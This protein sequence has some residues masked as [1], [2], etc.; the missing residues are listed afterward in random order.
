MYTKIVL[1]TRESKHGIDKEVL[2]Q[3]A[4]RVF[5]SI[6][7]SIDLGWEHLFHFQVNL[8]AHSSLCN[9]EALEP[10]HLHISMSIGVFIYSTIQKAMLMRL[11][12]QSLTFQEDTVSQ[13]IS[14]SSGSHKFSTPSLIFPK[15]LV[16]VFCCFC[17]R[18]DREV[19]NFCS[20][21]FVQLCF[22]VPV[23]I[24]CKEKFL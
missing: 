5:W 22:S 10:F 14:Y 8:V 20:L 16:Q 13:E 9:F 17:I 7:W 6:R 18:Q 12:A 11:K 23:F 3:K 4:N 24:C 19:H 1:Y 21:H 2:L 15:L